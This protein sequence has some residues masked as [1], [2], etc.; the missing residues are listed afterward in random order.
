MDVLGSPLLLGSLR[1][2][3]LTPHFSPDILSIRYGARW[4]ATYLGGEGLGEWKETKGC[5]E[6]NL[7]FYVKKVDAYADW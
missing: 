2:L 7:N 3:S 1:F 5:V 4:C 6:R